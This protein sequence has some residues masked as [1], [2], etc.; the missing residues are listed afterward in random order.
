MPPILQLKTECYP[1]P[2]GTESVIYGA[3]TVSEC[4]PCPPGKFSLPK[5][6]N[7][8][9]TTTGRAVGGR[10]LQNP[11]AT[12]SVTMC[13]DCSPGTYSSDS[14]ASSCSICPLGT[15]SEQGASSCYPCPAG[16]YANQL[17]CVN[18]SAFYYSTNGSAVCFPCPE[19]T[20][21]WRVR[22][23]V[24]PVHRVLTETPNFL[25]RDLSLMSAKNCGARWYAAKGSKGCLAVYAWNRSLKIAPARCPQ[26]LAGPSVHKWPTKAR[27][28]LPANNL[29]TGNFLPMLPGN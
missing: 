9:A 13:E 14:G 3:T 21:H 5:E 29:G 25:T 7:V 11:P 17:T 1:C 19:G 27:I 2:A 26:G 4:T 28:C 16:Q 20:I 15:I 24:H 6:I 12:L 18:C 22:H 23:R 8:T 10:Q